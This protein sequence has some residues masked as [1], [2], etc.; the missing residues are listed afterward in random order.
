MP[1]TRKI[2]FTKPTLTGKEAAYVN[3]VIES[4][5]LTG[6]GRFLKDCEAW[7]QAQTGCPRVLLTTSCTHALEI[8]ALLSGVGP[9]DEVIMPSFTF[10]STAN[11]FALRGAVPVF[12]DNRADTL[13]IDETKIEAA[14]TPRT[15]AIVPVHYAGI[16]CDMD[17]IMAIAKAHKLMVVED[18]AQGL[19]ASY[20]G[21]ALGTIGATGTFS[22]HETKNVVA[23]EGGAL[24]INDPEL[25]ERAQNIREKGTNRRQFLLGQV[26]KYTW[27]DVGSA[28]LPSELMAAFLLGQL[29]GAETLTASRLR[30]WNRYH[31]AFADL[32]A[33]EHLRRPIVPEDCVHN[34]HIYYVLLPSRA[35]RD[36]ALKALGEAGIGASFHFVPLESA[37]AGQKYSRTAGSLETTENTSGRLL[38]LPLYADMPDDDQD[39]VIERMRQLA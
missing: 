5:K 3:E 38:R 7:L 9:G 25:V 39:H 31:D 23:G 2:P 35:A 21:K 20:K 11:A 22:F 24:M 13:N 37:P 17:A 16:S 14:I 10:V 1:V 8:S 32:E 36:A 27:V 15:K 6:G 34:A 18:S 4:G 19:C 28:F 30:L 26:D 29:E 12:I 33:S